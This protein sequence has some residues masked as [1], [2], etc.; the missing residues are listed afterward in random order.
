MEIETRTNSK[1]LPDGA[2]ASPIEYG[3]PLG[4]FISTVWRLSLATIKKGTHSLGE[5]SGYAG[6]TVVTDA[7]SVGRTGR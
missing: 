3:I 1:H 6:P 4:T 5:S 2:G 7:V